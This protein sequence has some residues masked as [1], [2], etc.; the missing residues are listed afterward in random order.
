[1]ATVGASETITVLLADDHPVVRSGLAA[2]LA[3]L[4]GITVVAEADNGDEAVREVARHRPDVVVMDLRMP[5]LDGVEATRLIT[6]DHPATSV[7]VLTMF[8]EDALV[9]QALRAGARGYLLKVARQDEIERA[10]RAVA[11]GDVIF[12]NAVAAR[13]LGTLTAGADAALP[14]LSPREREVLDLMATGATNATIA[15]RL[16]LSP[17]TV[18]NHISAIFLKLGVSTRGEA[19]VIAKDVGL[20]ACDE[21][22]WP[23]G[24][25]R[26]PFVAVSVG[27]ILAVTTVVAAVLASV[28]W[29][30]FVDSY[31]L[32]NLVIGA[33]FFAAGVTISWFRARHVIGRLLQGSGLAYLLSAAATSL[34]L[35]GLAS[36]WPA[37]GGTHAQ[38]RVHRR[39]AGRSG[40]PASVGASALSRWAAPAPGCCWRVVVWG[41]LVAGGYQVVTG[42]LS[43]GTSF[44]DAPQ[45]RSILSVGLDLPAPVNEVMGWLYTAADLAVIGSLVVRYVRGDER[46]RRQLLWLILALVCIVVVQRAALRHRRRSDPAAAVVPVHPGR[47][48][49]RHRPL[50]GVRRLVL[51]R[52]LLYTLIALIIATY[53]RCGSVAARAGRRPAA[54]VHRCGDRGGDRLQP[55]AAELSTAAGPRILRHEVRSAR[56]GGARGPGVASR[57]RP[58]RRAGRHPISAA[59]AVARGATGRRHRTGR[60]GRRPRRIARVELPLTYRG[61]DQGALLVGLRRGESRLHDA[62]RRALDLIATSLALALHA[63]ALSEEVRAARAA[64]VESAAAEQVR[65][66]A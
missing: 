14:Q 43:D 10:I 20:D 23:P 37:A 26:R 19:I 21:D 49:R 47:D 18:G 12:S 61:A 64:A 38:H 53:D 22:A 41:R 1:M 28:D 34:A 8:H 63:T 29:G 48:R 35:L 17:K 62:D 58:G 57:R 51:S 45:A 2:L 33:G 42:V 50:P 15:H 30:T 56:H 46:V 54:G 25:V 6:S 5:G 16:T 24:G 66:A 52:T 65:A 13:V 4:P 11:A 59:A 7:L 9:T 40:L 60:R 39:L 36:G 31:T 3:T 27:A 44:S 32:T 55:A